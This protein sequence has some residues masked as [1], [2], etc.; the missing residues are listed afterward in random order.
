MY[1]L[2]VGHDYYIGTDGEIVTSQSDALRV[3]DATR[4]VHLKPRVRNDARTTGQSYSPS[5]LSPDG[6]FDDTDF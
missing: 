4:L 6:R 3:P 5:P 1:I 2:K